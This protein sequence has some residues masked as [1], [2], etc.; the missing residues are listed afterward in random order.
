MKM[1]DE[2]VPYPHLWKQNRWFWST[3]EDHLP[4]CEWIK[5]LAPFCT[6]RSRAPLP[7]RRVSPLFEGNGPLPWGFRGVDW[8]WMGLAQKEVILLWI[9]HGIFHFWI[10]S[11]DM[12]CVF[13]LPAKSPWWAGA[14]IFVSVSC[15]KCFFHGIVH[16][17]SWKSFKPLLSWVL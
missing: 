16:E 13:C 7:S 4:F 1:D 10:L 2:Q 12:F 6:E 9:I 5:D 17:M 11:S 15:P 8:E 14:S 3:D